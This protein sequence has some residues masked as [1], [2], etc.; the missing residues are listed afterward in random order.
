MRKIFFDANLIIDL[1]NAGNRFHTDLLFLFSELT[2]QKKKL[3][4]SPTTFAITY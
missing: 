2:R 4:V 3:Y 1:V